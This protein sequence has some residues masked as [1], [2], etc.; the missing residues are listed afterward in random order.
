[1]KMTTLEGCR[2]SASFIRCTAILVLPVG[3]EG[4]EKMIMMFNDN[5][6]FCIGALRFISGLLTA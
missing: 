5:Q 2:I 6:H 1:M 4:R 3:G